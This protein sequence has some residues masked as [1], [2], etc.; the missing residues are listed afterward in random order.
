MDQMRAVKGRRRGELVMVVIDFEEEQGVTGVYVS[1][2]GLRTDG[3]QEGAVQRMI[4]ADEGL[5]V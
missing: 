3:E 4:K 5:K 1:V 2:W